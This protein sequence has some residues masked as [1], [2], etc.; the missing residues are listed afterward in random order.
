MRFLA[1]GFLVIACAATL[2]AHPE[3]E[4]ALLRLN[5]RIAATPQDP[6]LYL[7]RGEL[8]SRHDDW[9]AAEANYLIAVEFAPHLPGL[10]RA[11]GALALAARE[12]AEARLHLNAALAL[13]PADAASLVLRARAHAALDDRAAA[14]ADYDAALALLAAPAPDLFLERAA[15]LEAP[16]A[17]ESLEHAIAQIGP[18]IALQLRTLALEQSLGRIDAAAARLERIAAQ[19]ERQETWHKQRGDLLRQA[20]RHR[21]ARAAYSAALAALAA[22]PVWLRESPESR[23]L[24]SELA[25]LTSVDL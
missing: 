20:G 7:E 9:V 24:A 12:P 19:S 23:Q 14:V 25:R 22:Q 4:A 3:I 11:R 13:E 6:S 10:A 8:Y 15:L 21:E 18:A 17:I 16:A 5:A 2:S 1:S